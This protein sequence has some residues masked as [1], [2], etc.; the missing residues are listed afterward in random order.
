MDGTWDEFQSAREQMIAAFAELTTAAMR[1]GV[2][3]NLIHEL[4]AR[5]FD[6]NVEV[7]EAF[8]VAVTLAR[9]FQPSRP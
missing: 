5:F 8:W 4:H 1:A 2:D 3:E 9:I 7:K 6:G